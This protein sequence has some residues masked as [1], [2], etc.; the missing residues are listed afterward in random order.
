[1]WFIRNSGEICERGLY[2][3]L[4]GYESQVFLNVYEVEDNQ[5]AHYARLADSL[6]GA[7]T[8]DVARSL[9]RLLLQ[10]LHDAFAVVANSGVLRTLSE[11]LIADG[12]ARGLGPTR[13]RVSKLL[14]Y[15]RT[16]L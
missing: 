5:F 12:D 4:N 3:A 8:P 1:M 2:V 16:V 14:G 15:R 7:G 11:A 10:P 13:R 9:K 6:D